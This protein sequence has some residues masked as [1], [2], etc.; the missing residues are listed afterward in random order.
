MP[1][2]KNNVR[3]T[4][5]ARQAS[6]KALTYAAKQSPELLVLGAL[7]LAEVKEGRLYELLGYSSFDEY[8]RKALG[9]TADTAQRRI[10]AAKRLDMMMAKNW[11]NSDFVTLRQIDHTWRSFLA[12]DQKDLSPR[13]APSSQRR[14]K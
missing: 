1:S 8:T 3:T 9:F 7:A 11:L 5:K 10:R 13:S 4:R 2:Q 14:T 12:Y 6:S